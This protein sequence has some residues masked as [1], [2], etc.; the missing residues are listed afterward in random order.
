MKIYDK[1]YRLLFR[2]TDD[3]KH[4]NVYEST[5]NS[6]RQNRDTQQIQNEV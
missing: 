6:N 4:V 3:S 2:H 1:E 5:M